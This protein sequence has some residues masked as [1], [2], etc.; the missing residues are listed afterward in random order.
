MSQLADSEALWE[1]KLAELAAY[2][3]EHGHCNVPRT[4]EANKEL[5]RWVMRQRTEYRLLMEGKRSSMTEERIAMLNQIGFVWET[6]HLG[7]WQLNP[8]EG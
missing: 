3:E 6:S 4:Y 5:E 7:A 1:T 2:K 8:N